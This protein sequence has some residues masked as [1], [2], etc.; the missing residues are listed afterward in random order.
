MMYSEDSY[1]ERCGKL[2]TWEQVERGYKLCRQC[3]KGRCVMK[4][5]EKDREIAKHCF[6]VF[7]EKEAE[8]V[9]EAIRKEA[10]NE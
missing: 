9:A 4:V 10:E 5:T 7:S 2:L 1:C 8:N 3:R 6:I